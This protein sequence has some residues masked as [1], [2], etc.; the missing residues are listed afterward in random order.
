MEEIKLIRQL[1]DIGSVKKNNYSEK[2]EEKK[3]AMLGFKKTASSKVKWKRTE[4][5]KLRLIFIVIENEGPTERGRKGVIKEQT[6]PDHQMKGVWQ[7]SP[8]NEQ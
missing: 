5:K 6:L 2:K 4:F 1:V 3:K 8:I 7:K